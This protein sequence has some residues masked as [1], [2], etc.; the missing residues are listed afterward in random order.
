M[1]AETTISSPPAPAL[2]LRR[3]IGHGARIILG[4]IFLVAGVL[5]AFDPNEFAHQIAGYGIIAPALSVAAAPQCEEHRIE[6]HRIRRYC[7]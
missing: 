6:E 1:N 5:K 4:L 7:D 3:W 2:R